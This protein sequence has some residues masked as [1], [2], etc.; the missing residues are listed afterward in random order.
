MKVHLSTSFYIGVFVLLIIIIIILLI[1][2]PTQCCF[3]ELEKYYP[4]I[5]Y[6]LHKNEYIYKQVINEIINTTGVKRIDIDNHIEPNKNL[7]WLDYSKKK[8]SYIRGNIKI[9]PLYYKDNYYDNYKYFPILM[10]ILENQ[11]NILNVYFWKLSPDSALLQHSTKTNNGNINIDESNIIDLP[12]LRYTLAINVLSC[13]EEECS[14]WVDGQLKQLVFDK[15]LLWDPNKEFSLHN[16]SDTDG[17]I[18][19]LNIDLKKP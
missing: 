4:I 19:F 5:Y 18:L 16:D 10:N 2:S 12:I 17:D 6:N 11:P 9:L 8:Y 3:F 14:L 15:Y 7:E 1:I 13:M